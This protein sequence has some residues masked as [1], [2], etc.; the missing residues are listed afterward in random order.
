MKEYYSG[1]GYMVCTITI[2][3]KVDTIS[4]RTA[5]VMAIL[6]PLLR[7]AMVRTEKFL[8][9]LN[10]R[11]QLPVPENLG[12]CTAFGEPKTAVVFMS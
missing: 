8:G 7:A 11:C 1:V 9:T 12:D 6:S 3:A 5:L 2:V 4:Q 10:E